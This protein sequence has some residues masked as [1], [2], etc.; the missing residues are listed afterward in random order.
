MF[1]IH[2]RQNPA[3]DSSSR[4][5]EMAT[6][7]GHVSS[8]RPHRKGTRRRAVPPPKPPIRRGFRTHQPYSWKARLMLTPIAYASWRRNH[9]HPYLAASSEENSSIGL[10]FPSAKHARKRGNN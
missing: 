9:H 8:N 10:V 6:S 4:R 1:A 2:Q 7:V 3:S 5:S